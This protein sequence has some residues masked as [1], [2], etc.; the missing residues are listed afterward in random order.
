MKSQ[1]RED[2]YRELLADQD[3][4]YDEVIDLDLSSLQPLV[5]CPHQPDNVKPLSR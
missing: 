3:A 5:A 2:E 1:G 4:E